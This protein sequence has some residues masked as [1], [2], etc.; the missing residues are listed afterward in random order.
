MIARRAARSDAAVF[1]ITLIA[2]LFLQ[3]D[4]TIIVGVSVSLVL[5]LNKASAPR[6][7]SA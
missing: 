3:L 4:T 5:F 7:S 6:Y 2:A 1:W